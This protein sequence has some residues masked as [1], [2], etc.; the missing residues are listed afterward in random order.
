MT[1]TDLLDRKAARLARVRDYL[2]PLQSGD[3]LG[4]DDYL[5]RYEAMPPDVRAELISGVVYLASPVHDRHASFHAWLMMW[6]GLYASETPCCEPKGAP[7]LVLGNDEAPEPDAALRLS[8]KGGRRSKIV[9]EKILSGPVELVAEVAD[10]S[11]AIDLHDKKAVYLA[12]GV[13]E[14]V[15]VAVQTDEVIWLARRGRRWVQLVPG[16]DGILKSRVFPGSGSIRERCSRRTAG[17][18]SASRRPVSG[19]ASTAASSARSRDA[20]AG[21]DGD[22]V[23]RLAVENVPV[24]IRLEEVA[25]ERGPLRVAH[26][27]LLAGRGVREQGT[28]RSTGPPTRSKGPCARSK[29]PHARSKRPRTRSKRPG[30]R[31]IGPHARSIGPHARSIGPHARSKRP[32]SRSKRPGSRS[33]GPRARSKRPRARSKRPPARSMGP[34]ASPFADRRNL[35]RPKGVA[36]ALRARTKNLEVVPKNPESRAFLM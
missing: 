19:R 18:S 7:T 11:A 24:E 8:A 16:R 26:G 31:S 9:R 32:G 22:V 14:Y 35:L 2:P 21:G 25:P 27:D 13:H 30:A 33:I 10:S 28:V 6:L 12:G 23:Y 15:V 17:G 36:T 20:G 34:C 29:R 4:I 3:R 1:R 5:E